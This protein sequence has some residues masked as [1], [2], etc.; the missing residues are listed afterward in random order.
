MRIILALSLAALLVQCS[1]ITEEDKV[2]KARREY[3][4][5]QHFTVD[6]ADKLSIELKVQNK[7]GKQTL[8]E[9]TMIA[10]AV[11]AQGEVF[12]TEQF[13]VDVSD[14]ASMASKTRI[15]SWTIPGADEK[16]DALRTFLAPDGEG[17]EYKTYKEFI[18]V[19]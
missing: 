16:L 18:R 10:E 6:S 11:D 17:T 14:I 4:T 7:S 9:I 8:Q 5:E 15:F 19:M 12:W 13:V 3:I 1:K 2:R